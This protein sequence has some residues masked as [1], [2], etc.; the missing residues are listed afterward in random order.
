[1]TL[2]PIATRIPEELDREIRE[3]MIFESADKATVVRKML[4]IGIDEWRKRYAV[5]LLEE[6]KASFNKAAEIAKLTVWEF[7]EL[8]RQRR[9]E[10]I[11]YT[12][13]ELRREFDEATQ[14]ETKCR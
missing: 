5:G 7:A 12:P 11:R 6:G 9:A 1:L 4:E 10:W 13:E 3:V 2:K 8:L 14:D